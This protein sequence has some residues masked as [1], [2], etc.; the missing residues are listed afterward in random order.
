MI[1]ANDPKRFCHISH[2][3]K[4][5]FILYICI[6]CILCILYIL[7]INIFCCLLLFHS[8]VSFYSIQFDDSLAQ[9]CGTRSRSAAARSGAAGA[10]DHVAL[11][12]RRIEVNRRIELYRWVQSLNRQ[13]E[14]YM[15]M[16]NMTP[17]VWPQTT[18]NMKNSNTKLWT[19]Q[20]VLKIWEIL[21]R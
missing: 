3:V 4:I 17:C 11:R 9:R 6:F 1:P 13:F 10:L 18:E 8:L 12:A 5:L 2:I 14:R 15:Y 20:K 7:Y 16:K 19:F 21:R